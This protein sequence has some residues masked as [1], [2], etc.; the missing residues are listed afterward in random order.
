ML[1]AFTYDLLIK[2]QIIEH[3]EDTGFNIIRIE[4]SNKQYF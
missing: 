4:N 3:T 1:N 2:I